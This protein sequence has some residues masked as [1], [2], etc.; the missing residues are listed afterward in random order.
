MEATNSAVIGSIIRTP[1]ERRTEFSAISGR[2]FVE[3]SGSEGEPDSP[4]GEPIITKFMSM[5]NQ[6]TGS[7]ARHVMM[8][9]QKKIM[10][11]QKHCKLDQFSL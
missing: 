11:S 3:R 9:G 7:T 10:D 1:S 5:L 4:S 6:E 8:S 2:V